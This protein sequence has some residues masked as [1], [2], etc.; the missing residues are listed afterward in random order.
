MLTLFYFPF[1]PNAMF[2]VVDGAMQLL[3][4]SQF[5][6]MVANCL[7]MAHIHELILQ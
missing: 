1:L 5:K 7:W 2:A 3:L 4:S 6:R